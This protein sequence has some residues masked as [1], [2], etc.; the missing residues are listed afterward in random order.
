M[1]FSEPIGQRL[2]DDAIHYAGINSRNLQ[3]LDFLEE[4][5]TTMKTLLQQKCSKKIND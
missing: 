5:I 2:I 1:R 4:K 3:N